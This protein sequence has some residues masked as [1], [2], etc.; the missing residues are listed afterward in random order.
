MNDHNAETGKDVP[1]ILTRLMTE[2]EITDTKEGEDPR[3]D[4]VF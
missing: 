3:T 2:P 4:I 1:L